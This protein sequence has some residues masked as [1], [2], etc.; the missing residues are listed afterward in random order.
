MMGRLQGKVALITGAAKG[1]GEADARLFIKEGATVVLADVDEQSGQ[2]LADEL[3]DKAIFRLLDVTDEEQWQAVLAET[4]SLFGAL[5]ILVNNAGI[6]EVGNILTTTTAQWRRVNAVSADGTFFGCKYA[7]PHIIASGGGS[8]INMASIA[9]L[10][11]EEYVTAYCAAKGAVE[12]LTR[13]VAVFCAQSKNQVRCNSI[14]P[15]GIDTPMVASVP[16]KMAEVEFTPGQTLP[17]SKIGVANDVAYMVL[18]LASDESRF[19][20]GTSMRVDNTMSVTAGVVQ[21]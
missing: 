14:H 9:S 6:V 8:I 11:G 19:V 12:A 3:G 5:H 4:L 18:Y 10:Q 15:S 17:S 7:L 20:N 21:A 13:A 2:A 1:L 16:S